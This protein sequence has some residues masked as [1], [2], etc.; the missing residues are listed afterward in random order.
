MKASIHA[1]IDQFREAIKAVDRA[2][3][4]SDDPKENWFALKLG[5]HFE[6]EEFPE[7]ADV[8]KI[9]INMHPD[10]KVYWLQL[11][12]IYSQLDRER[13]SLG[14]LSMAHRRGLFDKETEY[15]QLAGLQQ[16]FDFPRKAAEVME[17][18]L[19]KGVVKDTRR[20]R[21][22]ERRVGKECKW[23]LSQKNGRET[24][25]GNT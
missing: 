15:M 24:R 14:V 16:Q 8:L 4:L 22:E 3:E 7:A 13:D 1:N 19:E 21:S 12:A 17:E 11:S 23:W 2:I 5:M 18:G 9:L 6:L 10:K 25:P 20:N